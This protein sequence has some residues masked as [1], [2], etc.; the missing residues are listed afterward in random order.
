MVQKKERGRSIRY[1]LVF[2]G[3]WL[4]NAALIFFGLPF[5][6]VQKLK[7][8]KSFDERQTS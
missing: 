1:S 8:K 7:Q 4:V 3:L 2:V 6:I 5:L